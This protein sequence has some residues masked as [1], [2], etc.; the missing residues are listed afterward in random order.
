MSLSNPT[1]SRPKAAAAPA[2][3]Q[4]HQV[5]GRAPGRVRLDEQLRRRL[6]EVLD[7]RL[8]G[9]QGR[10]APVTTSCI[11]QGGGQ[12]LDPASVSRV[13]HEKGPDSGPGTP[14]GCRP[15]EG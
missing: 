13:S 6:A 10:E 2:S 5:H 3:R 8:R 15:S 4:S 12:T 7:L 14:L 1:V 11:N 9:L